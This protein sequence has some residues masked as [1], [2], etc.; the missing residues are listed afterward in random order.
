MTTEE[1]FW[2]K[3]DRREPDDCWKREGKL[4]SGGYGKFEWQENGKRHYTTTHRMAWRL[5]YGPIPDGLIVRHRCTGGPN[6]WCC[7]PAHLRLG[8]H[9]DNSADMFSDG[10]AATGDRNGSRRHPERRARG[11]R[12]GPG[13][14]PEKNRGE[15]NGRAKLTEDDV[16]WIRW[17][18][19]DGRYT[20]RQ[21]AKHLG[22][23]KP[24]IGQIVR[25]ESWAH[26]GRP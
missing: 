11:K 21:L 3:V 1:R 4:N 18:Y 24:V 20:Q 13:K 14:Y 16:R 15:R 26:V 9:K 5:T 6:R 10:N 23:S 22:V 2:S 7:N 8:T 25:G 12:S 19:K 17:V